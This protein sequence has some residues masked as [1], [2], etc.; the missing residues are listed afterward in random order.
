MANSVAPDMLEQFERRL[1]ALMVDCG[2]K[3]C[4]CFVFYENNENIAADLVSIH[5]PDT[6]LTTKIMHQ[7]IRTAIIKT[8]Y[9]LPG[10]EGSRQEQGFI[11]V[12]GKKG[13]FTDHSPNN[14][15][16]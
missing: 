3:S 9:E 10:A 1:S 4:N 12:V 14:P 2:I 11:T 5:D 16:V 6:C 8:A 13:G 15:T 7:F